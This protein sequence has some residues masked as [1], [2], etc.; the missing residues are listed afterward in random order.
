[1][2]VKRNDRFIA[3]THDNDLYIDD[4]VEQELGALITVKH[5]WLLPLAKPGRRFVTRRWGDK[6]TTDGGAF[7][8]IRNPLPATHWDYF[9]RRIMREAFRAAYNGTWKPGK[10]VGDRMKEIQHWLLLV[11]VLGVVGLGFLTYLG[12]QS[13]PE[14][15]PAPPQ[16]TYM[17]IPTVLPDD[18]TIIN[19]NNTPVAVTPD[20]GEPD[21]A[22]GA[23]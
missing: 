1:M 3:I 5:K 6:P 8:Y 14:D 10:S 23:P 20:S 12:S 2:A 19:P 4:K 15:T 18:A 17:G 11:V 7:V 9:G 16:P 21:S 22:T 13:E